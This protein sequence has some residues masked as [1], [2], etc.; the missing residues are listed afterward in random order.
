MENKYKFYSFYTNENKGEVIAVTHYAG[1]TIKG[2][3]KC[4]PIDEFD[5]KTGMKLAVARAEKKVAKA[6]V[7]NAANKYLE[8]ARAADEAE[9]Y[10]DK[11]KQYYMDSVDQLE[12]AEE[13]LINILKESK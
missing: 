5:L 3:A 1:H 13:S 9:K 2:V 4:N 11:M 6:K 7:R 10:F 12:E 8:A